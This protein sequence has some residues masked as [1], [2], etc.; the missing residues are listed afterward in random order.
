MSARF[1]SHGA[2]TVCVCTLV[3]AL[4]LSLQNNLKQEIEQDSERFWVLN[5]GIIV[6]NSCEEI[7]S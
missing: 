7:I 3:A 6:S 2:H 4:G 5:E 1:W